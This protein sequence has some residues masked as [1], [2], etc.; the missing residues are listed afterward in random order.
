LF[1]V[2]RGAS[3]P[4]VQGGWNDLGASSALGNFTAISKFIVHGGFIWCC[5]SGFDAGVARYSGFTGNLGGWEP[6]WT[7]SLA[8]DMVVGGDG[9]LYFNTRDTDGLG[10]IP[11]RVSAWDP[12][13]DTIAYA[14][15]VRSATN[16][17]VVGGLL[18]SGSGFDVWE[19]LTTDVD[20][21]EIGG[22]V[23]GPAFDVY[24]GGKRLED[25][26]PA[27]P[28]NQ[29]FN[30]S[31]DRNNPN[32]PELAGSLPPHYRWAVIPE[33]NFSI[34]YIEGG[35]SRNITGDYS[36]ISGGAVYMGGF[37]A[38]LNGSTYDAHFGVMKIDAGDITLFVKTGFED[39]AL[40][41]VIGYPPQAV[42]AWG[43][44][45]LIGGFSFPSNNGAKID[46]VYELTNQNLVVLGYAPTCDVV[47][48]EVLTGDVAT[49]YTLTVNTS[50]VEVTSQ[51][52]VTAIASSLAQKAVRSTEVGFENV[53]VV[54]D[55]QY[56]ERIVVAGLEA[57][58]AV[59]AAL[60]VTG[61]TGT[62]ADFTAAVPKVI[63][64]GNGAAYDN[65]TI[66]LFDETVD[67]P[68]IDDQTLTVPEG[69]PISEQIV[70]GGGAVD[71][72]SLPSLGSIRERW[73]MQIAS[74]GFF[75]VW[76]LSIDGVY[77]E[78]TGH[79]TPTAA[80][81]A[82]VSLANA[83]TEPEF[84]NITFSSFSSTI[85]ARHN[86]TGVSFE[87][88][89]WGPS[90]ASSAVRDSAETSSSRGGGFIND[91]AGDG[92]LMSGAAISATGLVTAPLAIK[93]TSNPQMVPI[94]CGNA[95]LYSSALLRVTVV[96]VPVIVDAGDDTHS[97][98]GL[99]YTR[100]V[101]MKSGTGVHNGGS[102]TWAVTAGP[103]GA[104]TVDG[105]VA[106]G[107]FSFPPELGSKTE[108]ITIQ[109]TNSAG[110]DTWSFDVVITDNG[111]VPI[112]AAISDK[113]HSAAS[114]A[115]FLTTTA[116]QGQGLSWSLDDGPSGMLGFDFVGEDGRVFWATPIIGVYNV[117]MRA[118]NYKG[119][120]TE[121]FQLTVNA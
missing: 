108:Q 2:S 31:L 60:T 8:S 14:E 76:R 27:V 66:A 77:V 70:A 75:D 6:R 101:W 63:P 97:E 53:F 17:D 116:T 102:P 25:T 23:R 54:A 46:D 64:F 98:V 24:A 96:E 112:V 49:T 32:D 1:Y 68:E 58:V 107:V 30:K 103:D 100:D 16:A 7:D 118:T 67:P 3:S 42:R 113:I 92:A 84:V 9:V 74:S 89:L 19:Y 28:A 82:L 109:A 93:T 47:N 78:T 20:D 65:H 35:T 13:T 110:S 121:S 81:S 52:N 45:L 106:D 115:F 39:G 40:G 85:R 10:L 72:W 29:T 59:S 105:V 11:S 56:P 71:G 99:G 21:G 95:G 44:W 104:Q 36:E 90:V 18:A 114:G 119:F 91:L 79:T 51:S 94:Y 69:D 62:V 37:E 4:S 83:N 15:G 50:S 86:F 88:V 5:G 41:T 55:S 111:V 73:E 120:D 33:S 48:A 38:E 34:S 61:G 26:P 80:A 43:D 57:G 12:V 87:P 22:A 117:T